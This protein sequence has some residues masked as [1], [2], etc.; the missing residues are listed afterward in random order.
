MQIRYTTH[1]FKEGRSCV[2]YAQELDG[3][4]CGGSATK[5]MTNLQQAV[6]LFLD[7][8]ERMGTLGQILREAGYL[9]H[10]KQWVGPKFV[11]TRRLAA[12]VPAAHVEA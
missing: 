6:R 7:E 12:A 2:A 5:A 9:R 3:S 4:S 8:A 10:G 1:V 11:A